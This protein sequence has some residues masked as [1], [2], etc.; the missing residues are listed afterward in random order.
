MS[1]NFDC[2]WPSGARIFCGAAR[3]LLRSGELLG[4]VPGGRAWGQVI[5]THTPWK[6]A[7]GPLGP[8]ETKAFNPFEKR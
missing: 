1:T 6:K 4:R 8:L 3:G 2:T 5:A 7:L